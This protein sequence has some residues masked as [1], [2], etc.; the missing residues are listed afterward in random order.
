MDEAAAALLTAA[1][2]RRIVPA[3]VQHTHG[4]WVLLLPEHP[5]DPACQVLPAHGRRYQVHPDGA[6]YDVAAAV[7]WRDGRRIPQGQTRTA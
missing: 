4:S 3:D 5:R 2:G 6:V 7:W 1:L